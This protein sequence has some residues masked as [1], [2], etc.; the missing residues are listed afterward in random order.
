MKYTIE[1]E[2]QKHFF[3]NY[4]VP[5]DADNQVLIDY[6]DGI[7]NGILFEFKL[8]INN[9][10][11]VLFQAIKYLS[12]MRIKGEFVPATILLIDLNSEVAYQYSSQNYINEIQT[13]YAGAAS[14]NNDAFN[15][16]VSPIETFAYSN[17]TE[18]AK[19]KKLI[20]NNNEDDWYIPIDIDENCI[21]GWATRYY[22][23]N[24][25]ASKG[26]FLGD[27]E[28]QISLKGEIR[29][30]KYF[31]GKINPYTK[32]T[33]EKFK[34]L[35]DC[36]NDRIN[37]KKLGAF[38]TPEPYCKKA[39]ELVKQ[40]ISLVPK[41]NDYVIIDRCAGTGNLEAAL[42]NEYDGNN[43]EILSHCIV[44]TY[45]YYEYKV[46][47]ERLNDKALEIIPPTEDDVAYESGKIANADAMTQE[48][49]SHPLI[50]PY[51]DNPKYTIILFENPPYRD[52]TSGMTGIK[53]KGNKNES[54]VVSEMKKS[55][56]SSTASNELANQFIWSGFNFYLRQ[57]TDSYILFSPLKFWKIDKLANK[58]FLNGFI[59]NR[60]FFHASKSA[61]GCMLF[62][63]KDD[64]DTTQLELSAYNLN[65]NDLVYEKNVLVKQVTF[66]ITTLFDK[67]KPTKAT[68]TRTACNTNGE[69]K[70]LKSALALRNDN[71]LGYFVGR[72]FGIS[73]PNLNFNLVRAMFYDKH[74]F[75]IQKSNYKKYLPLLAIKHYLMFERPWYEIELICCSADDTTKAYE[76]DRTFIKSCFI[77]GCLNYYNKC[78]SF[79]SA[80]GVYYRNELCFDATHG[81]TVASQDLAK[82]KLNKEEQKLIEL[83]NSV[84]SEAKK[85]K[86]YN[87][88]YTYGVYQI[89]KEL[90]TFHDEGQS[91]KPKPVADYPILNSY[92]ITLKAELRNYFQSHIVKKLY[93]YEL[94]K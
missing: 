48:Y 33:N 67:K 58:K 13:V 76:K 19:L 75:Y 46:L 24:P 26:D 90:N 31:K 2:G 25:T 27:G 55:S 36:L 49:I 8:N 29:T 74:G 17:I 30:P 66:P 52:Q 54:Y 51:I 7:Y 64:N 53:S 45:E 73:N 39:V 34:Y 6:T 38:Y 68:K 5:I 18:S 56:V 77:F 92:L 93:K 9:T 63:N 82:Y 4:G 3:K 43:S 89:S 10:G 44:S 35:M 65:D 42:E 60:D 1:K 12:K 71:I 91:Y 69:E 37:K 79:I 11:K 81:D 62:S 50:K 32:E 23:E 61:I 14:R 47:L 78:L 28:G 22:K 21:V 83:W 16:N 59:F 40:A 70:V 57:P 94:I 86:N 15:S 41:G 85:T 88:D 87:S 72:G 20:H 84:L 80:D